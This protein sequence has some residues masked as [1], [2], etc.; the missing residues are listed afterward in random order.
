MKTYEQIKDEYSDVS[1]DSKF[2]LQFQAF[3]QLRNQNDSG[4][5]HSIDASGSFEEFS[6]RMM[7]IQRDIQARNGKNPC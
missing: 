5:V 1:D 4:V 3:L 6:A 2:M 7:K